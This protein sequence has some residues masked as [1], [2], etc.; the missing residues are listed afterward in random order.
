[1]RETCKSGSVRGG[2]G[3]IPT[4]SASL[5]P[6]LREVTQEAAAIGEVGLGAEEDGKRDLMAACHAAFGLD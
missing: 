3:D 6:D 2:D 5:G 4:Y 1:M